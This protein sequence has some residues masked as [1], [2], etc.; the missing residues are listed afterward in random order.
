MAFSIVTGNDMKKFDE[1]V[2]LSEILHK[3]PQKDFPQKATENR[4]Y[5]I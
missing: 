2:K 5:I 1:F 4:N 3:Q